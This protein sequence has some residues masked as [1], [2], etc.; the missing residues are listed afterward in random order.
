MSR[1]Q[2]LG[3]SQATDKTALLSTQINPAAD[4]PANGSNVAV[5]VASN[6]F[7]LSVPVAPQRKTNPPVTPLD[8]LLT[9]Y[10]TGAGPQAFVNNPDGALTGPQADLLVQWGWSGNLS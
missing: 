2:T 9:G 6:V 5:P 8:T 4:D 10:P 7:A 3:A 1:R